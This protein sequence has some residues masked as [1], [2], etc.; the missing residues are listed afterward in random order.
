MKRSMW[1]ALA[2]LTTVAQAPL[3]EDRSSPPFMLSV[4]PSVDVP[5]PVF[6]TF[7][8]GMNLTV[9][10]ALPFFPMLSVGVDLGYHFAPLNLTESGILASLSALSGSIA[11]DFRLFFLRRLELCAFL[12]GGYFFAFLNDDP[13]ATGHNYYVGGG[14]GL[15]YR[16]SPSLSLGIQG[17]YTNF[18]G[19][20]DNAAV[21]LDMDMRFGR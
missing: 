16:F 21:I 13:A 4:R 20:Y 7:G 9:T 5:L 15:S 19:L 8:G 10:Y 12:S 3:A 11:M 18:M 2:I 17:R 6:F 14:L 1:V